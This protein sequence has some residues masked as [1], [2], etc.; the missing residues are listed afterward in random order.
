MGM[1]VN[2]RSSKIGGGTHMSDSR[3][4]LDKVK[5]RKSILEKLF[6][7]EKERKEPDHVNESYE[8]LPDY[9]EEPRPTSIPPERK[10]DN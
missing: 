8:E 1:N 9:E 4:I 6:E 3:N 7:K 5:D 2:I 10:D